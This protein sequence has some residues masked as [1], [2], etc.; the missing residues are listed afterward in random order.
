[1]LNR[2]RNSYRLPTRISLIRP[3]ICPRLR[4]IIVV[5]R[6]WQINRPLRSIRSRDR[7]HQQPRTEHI[8]LRRNI[9]IGLNHLPNLR[10]RFLK[11]HIQRSH[12][13]PTS[14]ME[15]RKD[16]LE[17]SPQLIPEVDIRHNDRCI[18]IAISPGLVIAR[19]RTLM[20]TD[21]LSMIPQPRR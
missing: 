12:N 7:R 10:V 5:P 4:I 3:P 21:T 1:M 6:L 19:I 9:V 17:V 14:F 11:I 2:R 20:R 16:S 8:L 13:H 18:F 15:L